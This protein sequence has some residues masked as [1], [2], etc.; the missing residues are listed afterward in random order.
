MATIRLVP[1]P[2]CA[3]RWAVPDHE[4]VAIGLYDDQWRH[5]TRNHPEMVGQERCIKLTIFDPD[6]IVRTEHQA[7]YP[8][9]E[10]KT[11]CKLGVH[12]G[13]PSLYVMVPIEY[14]ADGQHFVVTAH[15]GP[16]H[17]EATG[18]MSDSQG[19]DGYTFLLDGKEKLGA[20]YDAYA[21]VLYL[22]RSDAPVNAISLTAIEGHLVRVH[23]ESGQLVGFTIF[24][25]EGELRRQGPIK[26][27]VPVIGRDDD[28][29]IDE[30]PTTHNLELVPA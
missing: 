22:W 30:E 27:T 10:R 14:G 16:Y 11:L 1:V 3:Q 24:G 5:I 26:V 2:T 19:I 15:V 9:G 20:D 18:S 7:R 25:W 8:G 17:R 28:G 13:F 23:P 12:P 29:H 4:S 6:I 21:D